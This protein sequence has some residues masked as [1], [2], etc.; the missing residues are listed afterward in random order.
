MDSRKA[1]ISIF[2]AA[3]SGADELEILRDTLKSG[4]ESLLNPR[5][6][7]ELKPLGSF[8][9]IKVVKS[10]KSTA[11]NA[12]IRSVGV[13]HVGWWLTGPELI[14]SERSGL[15]AIKFAQFTYFVDCVL[16]DREDK[17]AV[18]R[19]ESQAAALGLSPWSGQLVTEIVEEGRAL[20]SKSKGQRTPYRAIIS[21]NLLHQAA[22]NVLQNKTRQATEDSD[23]HGLVVAVEKSKPIQTATQKSLKRKQGSN[24]KGKV[25]NTKKARL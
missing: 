8:F 16:D 25:V 5:I 19:Y 20:Q 1:P 15:A 9:R 10:S 13:V 18:T 6:D 11:K 24:L 3:K 2:S 4:K 14:K 12:Y 21:S 7:K 23:D 22:Q 17:E